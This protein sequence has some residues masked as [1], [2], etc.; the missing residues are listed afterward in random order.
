M[1]RL[2]IAITIAASAA[3]ASLAADAAGQAV[4]DPQQRSIK[5]AIRA[6][7]VQMRQAAERLDAAALYAHVLDTE[8]PPIIEDG[9]LMPTRAAALANTV[10]GLRGLTRVSYGYSREHVT[11]LSPT[12]ALWVGEGMASATLED[13]RQITAPF[14][15]S[16]LFVQRE[17]QWKIL[18]AHRSAPNPR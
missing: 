1:V 2:C 3:I 13:G 4:P 14:A 12:M 18:H 17:G 8:T 16:L 7:H 15:E 9:R 5:E 6:V 11:V 10:E